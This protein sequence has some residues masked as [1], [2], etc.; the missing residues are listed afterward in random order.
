MGTVKALK[1][2]QREL[3]DDIS[4][5][6]E[7]ARAASTLREPSDPPCSQLKDGPGGLGIK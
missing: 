1:R 7:S 5:I 4:L 3:L 6:H 2:S